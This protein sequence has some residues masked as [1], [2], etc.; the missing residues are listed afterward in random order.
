MNCCGA[1]ATGV[2]APSTLTGPPIQSLTE[3]GNCQFAEDFTSVPLLAKY[4]VSPTSFVF[5]F[6][7][8]DSSKSLGLSTCACLLAGATMKTGD[9]EEEE[10]VVRPYTPISTNAMTGSF[11]LLVKVY[12]DGK[13]GNYMKNLEPSPTEKPISFKHIEFN[14]KTQYPF[15][16]P[17][18]VGILAG[19]T[20]VTPMIQALHAILD[21]KDESSSMK[22]NMLYGSRNSQDILGKEMLDV[23]A[24]SHKD[25]FQI[26]HLVSN[27]PQGS[28]AIADDEN[29]Q[30]GFITKELIEKSFP[31]P[32]GGK[33][34]MIFV[35]GP[36]IMYEIMCGP[37]EEKDSVKGLLGELGYTP[38]QVYKF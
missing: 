35:C 34:V 11:D 25:Q 4:E 32:E 20:G 6:G 24:K 13:M 27:E 9:D 14:V 21:E 22:V 26:T 16:N 15:N 18:F 1:D 3:P 19:G 37:R 8:P 33:D 31:S 30:E 5:R 12:P 10:M 2:E 23:W 17:K 36:P 38:D 29:I 28:G 7:L